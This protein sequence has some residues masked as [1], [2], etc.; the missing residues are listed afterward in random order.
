MWAYSPFLDQFII[1]IFMAAFQ[2]LEIHRHT[3]RVHDEF[4]LYKSFLDP[5]RQMGAISIPNFLGI[6]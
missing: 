2:Y 3:I 1:I 5:F 6:P 4:Y